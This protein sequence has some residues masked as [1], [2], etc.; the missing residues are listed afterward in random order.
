MGTIV[1]LA[2]ETSTYSWSSFSTVNSKK[3]PVSHFKSGQDSNSYVKG[4][5][6]VCYQC[7]TWSP[8][9]SLGCLSCTGSHNVNNIYLQLFRHPFSFKHSIKS[10]SD[11]STLLLMAQVKKLQIINSVESWDHALFTHVAINSFEGG[12]RFPPAVKGL[13]SVIIQS[14][15]SSRKCALKGAF[16]QTSGA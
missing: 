9:H 2:E 6:Q 14:S 11:E 5:R 1:S 8:V 15:Y 10:S 12:L 3:L 7:T 13:F 4:G 16:Q